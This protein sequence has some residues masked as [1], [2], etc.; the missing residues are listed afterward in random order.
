MNQSQRYF[1]VIKGGI[2]DDHGHPCTYLDF[3]S[4]KQFEIGRPKMM[5]EVETQA[6][7]EGTGV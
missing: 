7:R 6:Q 5:V 2:N 4:P 3:M 1:E